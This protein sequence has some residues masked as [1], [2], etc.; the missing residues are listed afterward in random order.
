[1]QLHYKNT[2][3]RRVFDY[4]IKSRHID[5]D[6]ISFFAKEKLLYESC[7][8][9]KDKRKTYHNAVFVGIDENNVPR[10]G[11]KQ[12][13]Y[14]KGKPLKGNVDSSN[15]CYSFNYMGGSNKLYVFEAP[16]DMLAFIT[17]NQENWKEDNYLSLC[18]LSEQAILKMVEVYPNINQIILCLDNDIAGIEASE[19]FGDIL[20]NNKINEN[21]KK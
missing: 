15:S 1:M 6:I 13:L 8:I 20:L 11:H 4:L 12:G 3:M 21:V 16:I 7:E 10:H 17:M 19:K 2:N 5:R 18:G 9:S 14:T